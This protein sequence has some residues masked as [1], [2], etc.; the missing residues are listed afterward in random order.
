MSILSMSGFIDAAFKS[1]TATR[2]SNA[3]GSYVDGIWVDGVET[4]KD[5]DVNL[6]S[7]SAADINFLNEGGERIA[8]SRKVYVN[9]AT[10]ESFKNGEIWTFTGVNG[11]FKC[12]GLDNRPWRNYCRFYAIR[13]DE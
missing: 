4:A 8:D 12:N 9:S 1:V 10:D 6:Q 5:Y 2:K 7:L 13:M 11:N 3:T